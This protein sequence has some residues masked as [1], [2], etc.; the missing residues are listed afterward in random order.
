MQLVV[1]PLY[2]RQMVEHHGVSLVSW[3]G[4][5]VGIQNRPGVV[6]IPVSTTQWLHALE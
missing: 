1:Q 4:H 5:S 6:N 3:A 2:T